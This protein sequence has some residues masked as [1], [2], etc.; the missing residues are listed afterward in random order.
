MAIL[1][2]IQLIWV[3]KEEVGPVE[4]DN[5]LK[6]VIHMEEDDNAVDDISV[7]ESVR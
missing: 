7:I 5:G 4:I 2:L 1:G 6:K 3:P